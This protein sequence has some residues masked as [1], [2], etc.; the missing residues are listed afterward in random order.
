MTK[1]NHVTQAD[2]NMLVL[3]ADRM[4]ELQQRVAGVGSL[5]VVPVISQSKL[6]EIS[7]VADKPMLPIPGGF[8]V[9]YRGVT[10]ECRKAAVA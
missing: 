7:K 10:F 5:Y 6:I 8:K 1:P 2:L 9:K 3:Q 4:S